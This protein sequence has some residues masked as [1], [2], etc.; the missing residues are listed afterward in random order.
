M[1]NFKKVVH[2]GTVPC[3]RARARVFCKVEFKDGKLSISGVEGP[4]ASGN[5][6]G[7]CGQIDMNYAHNDSTHA[8]VV[9]RGLIR[10]KDMKFAKGWDE[11][12]WLKFLDVWAR[13]HLNEMRPGCEHQRGPEWNT[14]AP[15]TT[16]FY[17]LTDEV[18]KERKRDADMAV[19]CLKTGETLVPT[20]RQVLLA[21]LQRIVSRPTQMD[22][23]DPLSQ[24]YTPNG[25]QYEH[26]SY[27]SPSKT[28]R[29]GWVRFSEHPA[30]LLMKPCPVC[31][32]HYGKEW[33]REEVPEDVLE[34][35]AGLPD[36]DLTPAWV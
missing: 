16:Y 17:R 24:Y 20:E 1:E 2:V 4:L 33:R 23:S 12:K 26:D 28:E 6:H 14:E 19:E 32:Y 10:P 22:E 18:C 9:G 11:D 35:L 15:V 7:A 8:E 3:G 31:G 29:A 36:S 5:C 13:W 21:N 27:N 25:P 34:F 30:G